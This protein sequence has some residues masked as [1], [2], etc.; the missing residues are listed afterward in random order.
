M[1]LPEIQI[2]ISFKGKKSQLRTLTC[3][4]DTADVIRELMSKDGLI[5]YREEVILLCLNQ[6]NKVMGYYRVS[7]GGVTG[8]VADLRIIATVALNCAANQLILAHNHPSGS[9]QPSSADKTLTRK[10]Q[11]GLALLDIRLLDHLIITDESFFSFAN[12]GLM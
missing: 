2:S 5:H 11:E 4:E 8:T 9:L 12:E 1:N 10:A 7:A 3:A 6:A